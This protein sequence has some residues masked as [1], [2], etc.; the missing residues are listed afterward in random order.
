MAPEFRRC[1]CGH[2]A[3]CTRE[4]THTRNDQ[5]TGELT[6]DFVC[7][8]CGARFTLRP[9]SDGLASTIVGGALFAL[10][11]LVG[12]FV[13]GRCL[14]SDALVGACVIAFCTALVTLPC[15]VM[16]GLGLRRMGAW[17]RH[18]LMPA[19]PS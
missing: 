1:R 11:G 7:E 3:A 17:S 5:E 6:R 16:L 8:R 19:E 10:F 15:A 9:R 12:L 14:V 18:P 13:F 2:A 4:W